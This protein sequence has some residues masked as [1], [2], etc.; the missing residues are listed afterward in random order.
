MNTTM[1]IN[2]ATAFVQESSTPTHIDQ[3]LP[4]ANTAI[5]TKHQKLPLIAPAL[6]ALGFHLQLSEDFDTDT[7]GT[8]AGEIPRQLS[9]L[10]CVKTK[11]K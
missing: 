3:T 10:E 6:T 4:V 9:P 7:L 11:A 5:L 1:P 8:F 2:A